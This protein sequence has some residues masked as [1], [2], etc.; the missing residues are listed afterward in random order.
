MHS[1]GMLVKQKDWQEEEA[2][3]G[4]SVVWQRASD[5]DSQPKGGREEG[6]EGFS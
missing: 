2:Q 6:R 4:E 3:V 5:G 1:K